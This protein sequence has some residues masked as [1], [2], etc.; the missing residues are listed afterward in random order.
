MYVKLSRTLS[1]PR[2]GLGVNN[3]EKFYRRKIIPIVCP[4]LF[5]FLK[6]EQ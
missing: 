1:P 5:K 6:R 4:I 2:F 3:K